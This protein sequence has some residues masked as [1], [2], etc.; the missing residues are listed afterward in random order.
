ME[1]AYRVAMCVDESH[2]LAR[3][4]GDHFVLLMSELSDY[5][6]VERL[7]RRILGEIN[8]PFHL[9]G[10]ELFITASVG[11]AML[12][13]D[14]DDSGELLQK[15]DAAR[16]QI[17]EHGGNNLAFFEPEMNARA[18]RRLELE[19]ALRR[20]VS[21]NQLMLYYQPVVD[22]KRGAVT[23]AEALLRWQHPELGMV[24]P[25]E[26][27]PVAEDMGL[28]VEIGKWVV[29]ECQRQLQIWRKLGLD[30]LRVSINVSPVQLRREEDAQALLDLL[31]KVADTRLVLELTESALMENSEGVHRFLSQARALG[32]MVALDDFGT[33]FSSLS[34]LRNFEFDVLKVDKTFID[35]LANTRDYGLVASI[36]S[37]GRILGM[38]VVA[39]GVETAEQVK[40]LRQIGCDYV[41]GF[42]F[43]KPLPPEDFYQFITERPLRE[44]G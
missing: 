7:G 25:A 29:T 12:P 30:E 5:G 6:E 9:G 8:K 19:S 27:I 4:G 3:L 11:I 34:Y 38:R 10:R 23:S 35:E 44:V 28:I 18:E 32:S 42:Y 40:R 15:A 2:T 41:Q 14:G 22:V 26:F 1:V 39:E 37:M 31:G 24:S 33:G 16:I 36:V 17:K 43:S 21:N 20:A 13:Q